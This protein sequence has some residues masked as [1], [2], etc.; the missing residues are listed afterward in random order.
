MSALAHVWSGEAIE[1]FIVGFLSSDPHIE[2]VLV[3]KDEEA[4]RVW[5]IVNCLPE[6]DLRQIHTFET[7]LLER[8][9]AAAIDFH[10]VDR[11]G[12]TTENLIPGAREIL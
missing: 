12:N 1:R 4:L 9:P 3:S 11:R 2:R 8:F 10:V 7:M 6:H 5:T